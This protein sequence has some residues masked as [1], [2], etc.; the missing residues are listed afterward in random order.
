MFHG[1]IQ[2]SNREMGSRGWIMWQPTLTDRG[3]L[4]DAFP[5]ESPEATP[6]GF[7]SLLPGLRMAGDV[8][9]GG[10]G[11]DGRQFLPLLGVA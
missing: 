6:T 7:I 3:S 5:M 4:P 8:P 2:I 9:S 1:G 11:T 10:G